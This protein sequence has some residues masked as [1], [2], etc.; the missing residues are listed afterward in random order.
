MDVGRRT[1]EESQNILFFKNHLVGYH[2]Q[3][4]TMVPL[5]GLNQWDSQGLNC[6][7]KTCAN[8]VRSF[9]GF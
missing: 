8:I 3:T 1:K 2:R 4:C 5:N 6:D 9:S 7:K